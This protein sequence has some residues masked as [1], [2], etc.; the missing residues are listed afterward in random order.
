M[1]WEVKVEYTRPDE[2]GEPRTTGGRR[3]IS[4]ELMQQTMLTRAGLIGAIA[5]TIYEDVEGAMR[6]STAATAAEKEE[7]R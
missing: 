5:A 4:D 3:A 1:T 6:T 2:N 7:A